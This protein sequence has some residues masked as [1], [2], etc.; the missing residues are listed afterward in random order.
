MLAEL[1]GMK[2][3]NQGAASTSNHRL[4]P[5]NP[6]LLTI[7]A[8]SCIHALPAADI[9]WKLTATSPYFSGSDNWSGV[10]TPPISGDSL[11]F[12]TAGIIGSQLSNDLTN[13][14]FEIAG[15]SFT[16][17]ASAYVIGDGTGAL[18][19]GNPFILTGNVTNNSANLQTINN[20]ISLP[21]LR[22]FSTTSGISL[23][24][25]LTGQGGLNFT[26]GGIFFIGGA[27]SYSGP[28]VISDGTLRVGLGYTSGSLSG[29][30][31][32]NGTL[33]FDK[34]GFYTYSGVVS[35]TG[36]FVVARGILTLSSA[37]SY[38]GPTLVNPSTVLVLPTG[39]DFGLSAST[40][41]TVP[42]AAVLNLSGRNQKF[43]GLEGIGNVYSQGTP[44]ANLILD[45]PS[46]Q[47]HNFSGTLG[48]LYP[49][50]ALTKA[51]PGIQ[52]LSGVNNY[53]GGT[54]IEAGTLEIG[55]IASLP[56]NVTNNGT[57]AF[58]K[59][60]DFTFPHVVSG[61]GGFVQAGY[62]FRFSAAQTYTGPTV[63]NNGSYLV[64]PTT[65]DFGLSDSTV[66]TVAAGGNLDISSRNQKFAGLEGGGTI[67]SFNTPGANLTLDLPFAQAHTFSGTLGGSFPDFSLTKSGNGTQVLSGSNTY[68]GQ[69]VV[70]AGNLIITGSLTT[71]NTTVQSGATLGGTGELVGI[72]LEDGSI[73][74]PGNSIGNL[75]ASS[76][77]WNAGATLLYELGTSTADLLSLNGPLAK[78]GT[79]TYNFTFVDVGWTAG[80]TYTLLQFTS[81]TGFVVGD[82]S[83]TNAGPF[84]GSFSLSPTDLKFTLDAIPEPG[85]TVLLAIGL[86]SFLAARRHRRGSA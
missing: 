50:F 40:V 6:V 64:L 2:A 21:G 26:G 52:V 18:N 23:G 7:I 47:T 77:T 8:A 34:E 80:S 71:S 42:G 81:S 56:G 9:T 45:V 86:L 11:V 4:S 41:V 61:T 3:T 75:T 79:G 85:S 16:P 13:S 83:F 12:D 44:G 62:I 43:A 51:G 58:S 17:S 60:S 76:L 63:V 73:L 37:Q 65:T 27:A 1:E 53:T 49:D 30:V 74:A 69:T 15:I 66:V 29:D 84:S 38:T 59:P 28:T 72:T 24:G 70:T 20:P 33:V 68:T 32:N 25:D 67:Y 5:R 82:F 19:A 54:T 78:A 10:N 36:G 55:S 39:V 48:S 22:S 46:N 35:G 14:S 31:T 57:L